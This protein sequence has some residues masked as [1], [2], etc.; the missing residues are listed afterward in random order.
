[1]EVGTI[2]FMKVRTLSL[3]VRTI[4][5]D[6]CWDDRIMSLMSRDNVIDECWDHVIDESLDYDI[7]VS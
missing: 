7:Y 5:V 1:M 4:S 6:K 3:R 2:S